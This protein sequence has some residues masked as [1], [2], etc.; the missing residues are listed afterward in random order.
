MPVATISTTKRRKVI[1]I[2]LRKKTKIS[3]KSNTYLKKKKKKR[4][5]AT[6]VAS[7]FT[8]TCRLFSIVV[9]SSEYVGNF[10]HRSNLTCSFEQVFLR[11]TLYLFQ[12]AKLI[13]KLRIR[14][15]LACWNRKI[16][17]KLA[18]K[19]CLC[20]CCKSCQHLSTFCR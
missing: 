5:I 7:T 19:L 15:G 17:E 13:R 6:N 20:F 14:N 10:G 16:S 18:H 1:V 9:T 3:K 8:H 4:N 11:F 2:T 12:Q